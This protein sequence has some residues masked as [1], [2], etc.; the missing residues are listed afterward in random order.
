[1]LGATFAF[2][3][4]RWAT[5]DAVDVHV[6][7]VGATFGGYTLV[8]ALAK[9]LAATSP[10]LSALVILLVALTTAI[11]WLLWRLLP[12][13][14]RRV[15]QV[16]YLAMHWVR[17]DGRVV[18][19][20]TGLVLALAV[21]NYMVFDVVSYLSFG[22]VDESS[23]LALPYWLTSSLQLV[24]TLIFCLFLAQFSKALVYRGDRRLFWMVAG[25]ISFLLIAQHG[26]RPIISLIFVFMILLFLARRRNLF[27]A[28]ILPVAL[29]A[30]ATLLVFSNVYQNYRTSI[31][32]RPLAQS[33]LATPSFSD[34]ATDINATLSNLQ[35]RT[36]LWQFNYLILDRQASSPL[37]LEIPYGDVTGQAMKN[38][39]PSILW[40]EKTVVEPDAIVA[41]AYNL[42]VTDYPTNNFAIIQADFGYLSVII[43]PL[44]SLLVFISM[45]LMVRA[46]IH[47]STLLWL[48]SGLFLYY[49]I[50]VEA[51]YTALVTLCR[52]VVL[53]AAV[54]PFAHVIL[55]S[56]SPLRTHRNG[57][58][59]YIGPSPR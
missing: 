53:V 57:S 14:I 23:S 4:L 8:D 41:Y 40:P 45:A 15:L 22:S 46:T 30:L 42:P 9:D 27:S 39:I 24:L 31:I 25:A 52:N 59:P 1:M 13:T 28:R 19:L 21:Y 29:A 10:L 18:L 35:E 37:D 58:W 36:A 17:S 11:T 43:V 12:P 16:R 5:L 50:E 2:G 47:Y 3:H 51:G 55:K 33:T 49:L 54:Y 38:S 56:L 48:I 6:L 32:A 7:A 26:R 20:L 44:Q 34:A